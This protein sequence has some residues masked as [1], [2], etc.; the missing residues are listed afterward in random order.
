M[1]TV[2]GKECLLCKAVVPANICIDIKECSSMPHSFAHPVL[3]NGHGTLIAS[4]INWKKS[5]T[6]M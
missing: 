2:E 6:V 5:S 3:V 1:A 4:Y